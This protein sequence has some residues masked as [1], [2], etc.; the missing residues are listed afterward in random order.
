MKKISSILIL[1]TIGLLLSMVG[2]SQK[3]TPPADPT[4]PGSMVVGQAM[5]AL[6]ANQYVPV[7]L[8]LPLVLLR[9]QMAQ[10]HLR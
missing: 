3:Q 10:L 8:H 2:C 6:N 4:E 1:I 5:G 7:I 9:G